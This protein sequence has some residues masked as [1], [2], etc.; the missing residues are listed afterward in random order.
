MILDTFS[1]IDNYK[2]LDDVYTALKFL[3]A[4]DLSSYAEGRYEID[5]DNIYFIVQ[6][7]DSVPGKTI[8]EAHRK[9]I[10]IQLLLS[11]EEVIAVA[12]LEC[13]KEL[14]EAHPE[15]DAW[16]YS[17]ATQPIVLTPGSFM[18][19]YP[20]DIHLPGLAKDQPVSCRKIVVKVRA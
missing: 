12:P 19:L 17:C 1:H 20:N 8:A 4:A 10:D 16:L 5:G 13:E 14:V 18:V 7:Y 15:S 2:G 11:G 6:S 3:A 9:Y